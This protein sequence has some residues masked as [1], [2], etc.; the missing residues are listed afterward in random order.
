MDDCGVVS[1][2]HCCRDILARRGPDFSQEKIIKY[3]GFSLHLFSS[4]LWLQGDRITEQ[5]LVDEFENILM[6]NGDIFDIKDTERNPLES[7]TILLSRLLSKVSTPSEMLNLMSRI[8][9]PWALVYYQKSSN[10]L[11]FGRDFF[12][13]Q[14]LLISKSEKMLSL[15]STAPS[16]LSHYQEL[17]ALGLYSCQL[18]GEGEGEGG[19]VGQIELHPWECLSVTSSLLTQLDCSLSPLSLPCPVSVQSNLSVIE[20]PSQETPGLF[21]Q[22]LLLTEVAELVQE[23]TERIREAVVTRVKH[24]PGLCKDC[25]TS[26][27]ACCHPAV[28]V[29]FSGGLD[30]CVLASTAAKVLP[31]GQALH[32]YNVAFQQ[33]GGHYDVPDRLTGL[34]G[35][36]E[37]L[38]LHPTRQIDFIQIDVTLQELQ[39]VRAERVRD[40]LHPLNSVLDDSIG[41]AVWLAGRGLGEDLRTGQRLESRARVLL[42]GMGIDEQLG[43]YSRHRTQHNRHGNT[44]LAAELTREITHISERNL[45]RDNRIVSDHGVAPRFPFLDENLVNFLSKVPINLKSDYQYGRGRGEKLLLRLVAHNMGLVSTALEP[46]R[47]VQFGSRI[48]KMENRKEKGAEVAV[49]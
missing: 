21:S 4:V 46:K 5:P 37:L 35:Y 18:P 48:A 44:G 19:G 11:W 34:Q 28:G 36:Q 26:R 38:A 27:T 43:G 9:G 22:L 42:L 45:G 41:C 40:L 25:V 29:L 8:H 10:T 3:P 20:L 32:L 23:F 12:G 47:A 30:S 16:Q 33:S 49:R 13:R 1:D 24:Q 7:D 31:P 6:W 15:T 14:S 39:T 2:L 17:P